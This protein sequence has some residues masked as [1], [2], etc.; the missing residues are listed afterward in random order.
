MPK[1]VNNSGNVI[2]D[3][4]K[5][6]ISTVNLTYES[7]DT[8]NYVVEFDREVERVIFSIVG[9]SSTPRDQV[10]R[11]YAQIGWNDDNKNVC[12]IAKGNGFVNGHILPVNYLVKFK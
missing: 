12:F 11:S 2:L 4:N 10:T 7:A 8:L 6:L 1:L 3:L 5:Y 9:N